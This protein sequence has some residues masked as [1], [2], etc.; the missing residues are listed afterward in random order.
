MTCRFSIATEIKLLIASLLVATV[1]GTSC[2]AES[3]QNSEL[4][5]IE[6]QAQKLVPELIKTTVAIRKENEIGSGVIIS[7]DGLIATAAHVLPKKGN[8]ITVILHDG[9]KHQGTVLGV[10]ILHDIGLAKIQPPNSLTY[11][12]LAPTSYKSKPNDWSFALG[13]PSGYGEKRGAVLRTGKILINN[14][15]QLQSSCVLIGGDSGGPLFNTEGKL[16]GIHTAISKSRDKN[17]HV[18]ILTLHK[19]WNSLL[20]GASVF[21]KK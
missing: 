19:N 15:Y 10:N 9:T 18:P 13:H 7:Q 17:F 1:F 8:R 20:I 11:A 6:Q 2:C 12:K 3:P 16:I 5:K 4:L 14:N 21:E